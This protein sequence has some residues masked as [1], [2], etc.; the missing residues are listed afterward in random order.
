MNAPAAA[1]AARVAPARTI[2]TFRAPP[3]PR[4]FFPQPIFLG[5]PFFYSDYTREPVVAQTSPPQVVVV[6]VPAATVEPV[7]ADKPEP[8]LIEWR[9]DRYMRMSR[10]EPGA[11]PDYAEPV[12]ARAAAKPEK[13]RPEL[14]PARLVFRDGHREEVREYAIADGVLYARGDYWVDGY[15]NKKVP[16]SAL[17]LPATVAANQEIGVAFV[18]P[19]GPNVVVTRP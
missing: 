6:Q 11:H 1:S 10:M 12:T 7:E 17:D 9:G 5:S 19:S 14:P 16:F 8:V 4:R 15:W 18:L 13:K 3:P 2:V